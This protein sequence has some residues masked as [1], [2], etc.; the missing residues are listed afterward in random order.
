MH[1][2]NFAVLDLNYFRV[3]SVFRGEESFHGVNDQFNPKK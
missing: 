2:L 3:V 1:E